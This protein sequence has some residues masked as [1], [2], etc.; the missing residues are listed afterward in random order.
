METD[1]VTVIPKPKLIKFLPGNFK[2]GPNLSIHYSQGVRPSTISIFTKWLKE[3]AEIKRRPVPLES[4]SKYL[5]LVISTAGPVTPKPPRVEAI[6]GKDEAY[7]LK[8]GKDTVKIYA[9]A[10]S[11]LFYGL[12]TFLH[13]VREKKSFRCCQIVDFPSL[14]IRGIHLDM[15]GSFPTIR[16]LKSIIE[17]LGLY[18]IN[19]IL[20]EYED[21]IRYEKHPV[22]SH[23]AALTKDE[24]QEINKLANHYFINI[25]PLQQ[26]LGHV[27]YIL[28]HKKYLPLAENGNIQQFCPSNPGCRKLFQDLVEEIME[29]HPDGKYFHIGG[30][31]TAHLGECPGCRKKGKDKI[32]LY[33]INSIADYIIKKGRRPIIWDDMLRRVKGEKSGALKGKTTLMYWQYRVSPGLKKG[34]YFEKSNEYKQTGFSV[35]GAAGAKGVAGFFSN[36]D[37][38][39]ERIENITQWAEEA[40]RHHLEGVI[41][42]A[43][44]RY[45]STLPPCGIFETAWQAMIASAECFWAGE[46]KSKDDFNCRFAGDFLGIDAPELVPAIFALNSMPAKSSAPFSIE[47]PET[48]IREYLKKVR[49]N[50]CYLE[51]LLLFSRLE[52]HIWDRTRLFNELFEVHRRLVNKELTEDFKRPRQRWLIELRDEADAIKKGLRQLLKPLIV[53]SDI[54]ELIDARFS[55]ESKE[56]ERFLKLFN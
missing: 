29:I 16:Y 23:Q 44:S 13:L 20:L 49:F 33:W 19:T 35:I 8:I 54:E 45:D 42:T 55:F 53:K 47:K 37:L 50:R 51:T 25:I 3:Y 17:T 31:E 56:V 6:I 24:W 5:W 15:K 1:N 48:V 27:E 30:D 22:I 28:K 4:K 21:K 32:Y 40:V 46:M 12:V 2:I 14:N 43:W 11:G 7:Y 38:F 36:L 41:S 34:S 26:C 9:Q 10:Q 18:K 52:R 39:E